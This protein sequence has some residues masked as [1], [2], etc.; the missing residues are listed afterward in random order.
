M[1][2]EMEC[3]FNTILVEIKK[4][5]DS[6]DESEIVNKIFTSQ[7]SAIENRKKYVENLEELFEENHNIICKEKHETN[8]LM[9]R[10][11]MEALTKMEEVKEYPNVYIQNMVMQFSQNQM[12]IVS[13]YKR[14]VEEA[15]NM[16]EMYCPK[17]KT[18]NQGK[19]I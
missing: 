15:Q 6:K 5:I 12:E 18:C 11:F 10:C 14:C 2:A 1:I 9:I 7:Y 13:K 8:T 17:G 4:R 16:H 3:L 19:Q